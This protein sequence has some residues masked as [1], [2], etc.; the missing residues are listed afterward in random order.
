[1][2][3]ALIILV[4]VLAVSNSVAQNSIIGK[5]KTIDDETNKPKSIVEIFERNGRYYGKVTNLFRT[6]EEEQDPV[7]EECS[8]SDDRYKK[9]IIGMEILKD[10]IRSGGDYTEGNILDPQNGKIYS[11]KIWMEGNNLKL[12]GYWG[13][14]FRTQ[15]WLPAH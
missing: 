6:P 3:F 15:T 4:L 14:F 1:M 9:K 8:T 12:R 13:L 11:C 5:W 10:M 2:K 7:C